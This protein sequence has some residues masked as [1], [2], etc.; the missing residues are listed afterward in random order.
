MTDEKSSST[1]PPQKDPL[2]HIMFG[3]TEKNSAQYGI[4]GD[5]LDDAGR[6]VGIDLNNAACISLFGAPGAGK[7]YTMGTI[8]EMAAARIP[9]I[10]KLQ[11]PLACVLFHYSPSEAYAPEFL[12]LNQPNRVKEQVD[13]LA[14][15]PGAVPAAVDE[16]ILLCPRDI[17]AKREKEFP[18]IPCYPMT[19]RSEELDIVHW[20]F[21]M[22]A[23]GEASIYVK[24]LN[25]IMRD[26]MRKGE[27]ITAEKLMERI[28][29]PECY[30][31][32]SDKDLARIRCQLASEYIDD[33]GAPIKQYLKSGRIIQVDLRD[34]FL[35]KQ[36]ALTLLIVLYQLFA[37]VRRPNGLA[38]PKLICFDEAHK[39]MEDKTLVKGLVELIREMRHQ[40][41]MI[42]VASQDP[43][44][45]PLEVKELSTH[46]VML[47]FN[48]PLWLDDLKK[49][50]SNLNDINPNAM[51][52]LKPGE[53]YLWCSR[54]HDPAY[55]MRAWK[56]QCRS[57]ATQH[58]GAT[59]SAVLPDNPNQKM[60]NQVK[61]DDNKD[62]NPE[63]SKETKL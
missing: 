17:V 12:T 40:S 28:N 35:L 61:T 59:K 4:L 51:T 47:R 62:K 7:S 13:L 25:S 39:Y 26:I 5:N 46:L 55:T 10:N 42:L 11:V 50:N 8:I 44:S 33:N 2:I 30:L 37:T 56:V 32:P 1:K 29:S 20:Q 6:I 16:V 38:L 31:S 23:L 19:F 41:A 27:V 21:L 45:V 24:V 18:G 22:G 36:E 48:S 15:Y 9:G 3:H 63:D 54:S 14:K 58:G 60:E 34:P 43:P 53:A 57:R 49:V 52:R